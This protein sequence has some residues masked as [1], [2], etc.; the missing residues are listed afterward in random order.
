MAKEFS[1]KVS[2]I[3]TEVID[4]KFMKSDDFSNPIARYTESTINH[5]MQLQHI[6]SDSYQMNI[7]N[8][9]NNLYEFFLSFFCSK[10]R[11]TKSHFSNVV[12]EKMNSFIGNGPSNKPNIWNLSILA[13]S[14]VYKRK[15]ELMFDA[16]RAMR[17][18][19][20]EKYHQPFV[21]IG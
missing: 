19:F 8:L 17:H 20:M 18:D 13:D 5:H 16:S 12:S 4:S 15:Y 2:D 9:I 6:I 7:V 11:S 1:N 3:I 21:S 10:F 14:E